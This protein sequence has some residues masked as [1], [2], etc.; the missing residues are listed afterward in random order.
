MPV[1]TSG[2]VRHLRALSTLRAGPPATQTP[3]DNTMSNATHDSQNPGRK[4]RRRNRGGQNRNQNNPEGRQDDRGPRREGGDR[5]RDGNRNR[6]GGDRHRDGGNRGPRERRPMPQPIKQLTLWEKIKKLFGLYKEP[7]RPT[8]AERTL[9]RPEGL[10]KDR[11]ERNDRGERGE[12]PVKSNIRIARPQERKE[13]ER[14][15]VESPRLYVGNLSYDV[16][17]GDLTELFKG[18]GGV[19]N[20]E[21]V[22]NRNT[23]RSKGYGFVEM[24]HFDDAKRSVEVLHDQPFMGR[25]LNVSGAKSKGQ[26]EREDR[27]DEQ[28]QEPKSVRNVP[29]PAPIPAAAP[30]VAA[31]AV[32]VAEVAPAEVA[33][34]ADVTPAEVVAESPAPLAGE[35]PAPVEEVIPAAVT[36][37]PVVETEAIPTGEASA[38]A[39]HSPDAEKVEE[40]HEHA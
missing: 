5:H 35:S 3:C 39:G 26:D 14:G 4:R 28:R 25:K 1:R 13:T 16:T 33:P 24:L 36:E 29:R 11:P 12:R 21:I 17:E 9:E 22:Y 19:R 38:P 34:A 15:P 7:V 30:V 27:E 10:Q 8:R 20:V 2:P 6:E 31:A 23:H 18:I 40:K 37:A 32:A